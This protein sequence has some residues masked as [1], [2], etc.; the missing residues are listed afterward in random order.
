MARIEKYSTGITQIIRHNIR[1][2]PD[3]HCYTNEHVDLSKSQDNYSLIRRG[4]TAKEIDEYRK[5]I[6]SECFRYNRKNLI[7]ANEVVCTLPADCPPEQERQFFEETYNYIC[8]TLPM[9]ERCI[10]LAEV[11]ADEGTILKDGKT[12]VQGAKHM[13]VMYVPAVPD[14]KHDDYDYKLCSD[15]LTKRSVLKQW[16]PNYQ[17]WLDDAGVHATVA[18]GITSGSG[19]SVKAMKEITQQ[20]GLS[21]DQ[22][23]GLQHDLDVAHDEIQ[24]LQHD[25]DAAHEQIRSLEAT[26]KSPT[27]GEHSWGQSLSWGTAD[28]ERKKEYER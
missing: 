26:L 4:S 9:G 18:S 16:H 12:V 28:Q 22:I 5:E 2:F 20:T 14:R 13:H 8:S 10:F 15:E 25:L 3:G 24:K 17:A 6:E 19:I 7:H 21:L 1:E 23:K 27:W 11:H